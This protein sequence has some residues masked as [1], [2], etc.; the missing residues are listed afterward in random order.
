MQ[1][2]PSALQENESPV[3]QAIIEGAGAWE[4]V[5]TASHRFDAVA[6]QLAGTELGHY[7]R[8]GVLDI[9]FPTKIRNA[10]VD[11]GK[12]EAHRYA[13]DSGWVTVRVR[14]EA[15]VR[16]ALCLLRL[17]YLQKAIAAGAEGPGL[18]AIRADLARLSLSDTSRAL[19]AQPVGQ[20]AQKA[21][22]SSHGHT[23]KEYTTPNA[24]QEC[25]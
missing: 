9:P 24:I 14:S 16:H 11:E 13:P 20:R 4:G 15:D 3:T 10:L 17:S 8:S 21:P 18:D 22:A 12:A 1:K 25:S 2:R 19:C 5:T 23:K 7:H 6:F